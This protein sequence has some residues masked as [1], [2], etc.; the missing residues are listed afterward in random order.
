MLRLSLHFRAWWRASKLSYIV[1]MNRPR[2]SS[3]TT[4]KD[5]RAAVTAPLT[6][7]IGSSTLHFRLHLVLLSCLV[8]VAVLVLLSLS[9]TGSPT[10]RTQAVLDRPR[11]C[12]NSSRV[13]GVGGRYSLAVV[14]DPD[15]ESRAGD[16]WQSYLL[17]GSLLVR[18]EEVEV[19]WG[20]EE[21]LT[22]NLGAAGRGMELSELQVFN[23]RL[24]TL[25]D[26]TGVVYSIEKD[27]V[28]PW[29]ILSDGPG[30]VSK[31]FKAE[32]STVVGD[33]LVVGGLGKEWTTTTG[34]IL[35]HN[36]MW[37]K[38][39]SCDGAVTHHDW[40]SH[41]LTVREAVG[42]TWPGYMIHE[43]VCWSQVRREWTFLPRRMSKHK[44][45][46]VT[47]E[48]MGS[49]VVI[50]AD[51]T[52]SSVR[53]MTVGKKRPTHGFS[54]CKFIPGTEDQLMVALK[55]EE[56]EGKVSTYM[57]VFN[58]QGKVLYDEQKIGDRK[59]EGVEFV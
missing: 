17:R 12:P 30:N 36:P 42:I 55:S 32:W 41:Y 25:D 26:R 59:F 11:Q 54:S 7:R 51:E 53:T 31:G 40:R 58:M 50:I 45:D 24:L 19:S 43:A 15:T 35:N 52:F 39:V 44:Y 49:N 23:G 33:R 18:G 27:K 21:L 6:Y 38:M 3:D 48:R 34:E 37:V 5:W 46:D 14:A 10:R 56:I 13:L 29:V 4:M 1:A 47:D 22:S 9:L 20:Q 28:V 2:S 8:S 16:V 57:M